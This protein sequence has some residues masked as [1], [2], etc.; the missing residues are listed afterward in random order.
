[1][2]WLFLTDRP[3]GVAMRHFKVLLG[4]VALAMAG[5]VLGGVGGASAAPTSYPMPATTTSPTVNPTAPPTCPPVLPIHGTVTAATPTSLTISYSIFLAPPCGYHPPV[6]VTL[7]GSA[8]DAQQMQ[9]P[10]AEAVSGS[11]RN[12]SVTIDGLTPDT[13]YWYRNTA[14]GKLDPYIVGTARTASRSACAATV[15]I[16]N[17]WGSGFLA[18]IT[19]RSVGVEPLDGWQVSWRWPGDERIVTLWNGVAQAD[20]TAITVR[21]ASWNATLPPGGST[22]FGMIVAA[23]APPANLALTCS[24]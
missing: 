12:G 20:G 21:N 13:A 15:S 9:N 17:T 22:T 1:M 3:A 23:G 4:G 14:G 11:E 8:E 24:G 18:T 6:T 19:V 5:L 2:V 10:V 7:F 16:D